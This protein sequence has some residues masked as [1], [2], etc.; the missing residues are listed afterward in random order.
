MRRRFIQFLLPAV[1]G[2]NLMLP[3][4]LLAMGLGITPGELDFQVRPGGKA[5][6][7]L[8]V[9]NQS[10]VAQHFEVYAEGEAADWIA[11]APSEFQLDTGQIEPVALEVRPPVTAKLRDYETTVCVVT[12]Q[13]DSPL[14]LGAGIKVQAHISVAVPLLA[15]MSSWPAPLWAAIVAALAIAAFIVLRRKRSRTAA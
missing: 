6:Q 1:V 4:T 2:L 5:S 13:P 7:T 8:H 14:H 10:D 9:I 11:I 12:L 15:T 3:T